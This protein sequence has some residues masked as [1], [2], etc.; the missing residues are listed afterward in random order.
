MPKKASKKRHKSSSIAERRRIHH[1]TKLNVKFSAHLV[2]KILR[3]CLQ[4]FS[5]V[6]LFAGIPKKGC[7]SLPDS[8]LDS[9]HR[10][11][12][13]PYSQPRLPVQPFL[14]L[15]DLEL[16]GIVPNPNSG[17]AALDLV[18]NDLG[19]PRAGL[20]VG[21]VGLVHVKRVQKS[22]GEG[23]LALRMRGPLEGAPGV[24]DEVGHAAVVGRGLGRRR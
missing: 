1:W 9:P 15:A 2:S 20:A 19:R 12:L 23:A 4:W 6:Y 16:T 11:A 21:V 14:R 7:D 22:V 18:L 24:L 8:I 3:R 17:E 10:A 13:A 5:N